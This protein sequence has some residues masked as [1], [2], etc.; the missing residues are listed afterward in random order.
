MAFWVIRRLNSKTSKTEV[1]PI[2][3]EKNVALV[4]AAG[5]FKILAMAVLYFSA[6]IFD[7]K[8]NR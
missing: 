3:T 2:F 8:K 4:V 6:H 1:L 5:F 7:K